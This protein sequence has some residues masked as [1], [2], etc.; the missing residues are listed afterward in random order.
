MLATNWTNFHLTDQETDRIQSEEQFEKF[1]VNRITLVKEDLFTS[2]F[3]KLIVSEFFFTQSKHIK[4]ALPQ[5]AWLSLF[6]V[7]KSVVLLF[8]GPELRTQYL[9]DRKERK[10]LH[11]AGFK[12]MTS[13]LQGVHSTT[14]LQPLP[15]SE[16][17][18]KP[19]FKNYNVKPKFHHF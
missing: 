15:I 14:M 19:P 12:P 17:Y 3:W 9:K 16:K 4:L 7:G 6:F 10:A 13:L 8:E 1:L 11:P 5:A 18:L 2:A